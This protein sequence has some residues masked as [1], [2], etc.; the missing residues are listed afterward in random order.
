MSVDARVFVAALHDH[1][2]DMFDPHSDV[3][4]PETMEML[5]TVKGPSSPTNDDVH[6]IERA[7]NGHSL[8]ETLDQS[9]KWCLDFLNFRYLPSI[10]D[11]FDDDGS[12]FVSISEVN[13]FTTSTPKGWSL[14]RWIA[15]WARGAFFF[16][17]LVHFVILSLVPEL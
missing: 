13:N 1:Y 9:D 3:R 8:G 6:A 16:I 17:C 5:G 4:I 14:L 12:G 11:A 7:S 2:Q 15:Y 10:M